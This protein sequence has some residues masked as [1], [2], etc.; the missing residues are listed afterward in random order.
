MGQDD[1]YEAVFETPSGLSNQEKNS[2]TNIA[3]KHPCIFCQKRKVKCDRNYPCGNCKRASTECISPTSLPPKKRKRRFPEAE[4]LA[5]IRRYEHHLKKCG[6]DLD[7]IN[8][9]SPPPASKEE[10]EGA[11]LHDQ[12]TFKIPAVSPIPFAGRRDLRA[13]I[14]LIQ[15]PA[16]NSKSLAPKCTFKKRD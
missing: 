9:E 8:S 15:Q 14:G 4:L 13:F 10:K 6:A 3:R 7:A 5:K 16:C 11:N 12:E 2:A 1:G